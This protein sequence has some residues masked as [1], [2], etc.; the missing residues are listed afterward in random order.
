MEQRFGPLP[1]DEEMPERGIVVRGAHILV[2]NAGTGAEYPGTWMDWMAAQQRQ[3]E[4][5]HW[6]FQMMVEQQWTLLEQMGMAQT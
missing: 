1:L 2:E 4:E 3:V 6:L 5:N